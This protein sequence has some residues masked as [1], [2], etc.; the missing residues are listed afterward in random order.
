M[1]F[2][3][4]KKFTVLKR[5]FDKYGSLKVYDKNLKNFANIEYFQL[6]RAIKGKNKV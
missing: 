4:L 3:M 2:R 1:S 6:E 5:Q